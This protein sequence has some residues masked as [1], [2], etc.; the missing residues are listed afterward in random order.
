MI[1]LDGPTGLIDRFESGAAQAVHRR[2]RDRVRQPGEQ[3]SIARH[4]A[5]VFARLVRTPKIDIFNL[6]LVDAGFFDQ[7]GDNMRGKII[8][9]N[10]FQ[11]AAVASHRRAHSFDDY[12]FSHGFT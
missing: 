5:R 2:S 3:G 6:F 4:V 12:G 1:G 11:Y 7:F 9:A 8:G 10:I